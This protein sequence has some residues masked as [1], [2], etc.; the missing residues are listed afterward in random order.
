MGIGIS[1]GARGRVLEGDAA[2]G[3]VLEGELTWG[4]VN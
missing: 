2:M 3:Q 4:R 1:F